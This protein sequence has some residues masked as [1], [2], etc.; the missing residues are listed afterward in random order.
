[1]RLADDGSNGS[2][3]S[4]LVGV[5]LVMSNFV[6][7]EYP[8]RCDLDKISANRP[9]LINSA[10]GH[11]KMVNSKAIER[12][13]IPEGDAAPDGIFFENAFANYCDEMI[14]GIDPNSDKRKE[15]IR[16]GIHGYSAMGL[17]TLHTVS[18]APEEAQTEYVDQYFEL[19]SAGELPVRIVIHPTLAAPWQL[20]PQTGFGTDMVR[21]GGL[22]IF[23]DGALGG[24]S[25]ALL[26]PYSDAP[27]ESGILNFTEDE[28][29]AQMQSGYDAG[30]EV[31]I[32]AI[33]DAAMERIVSAAEAVYP[34][35]ENEDPAE[36]LR[37]A[38]KRRLRIIHAMVVNDDIIRRL[39]RLP[40]ILDVQPGFIDDDVD[41]AEDRLGSERVNYFLPLKS[42]MDNGIMVAGGSDYPFGG[43]P[44]LA[45]IQCAVTRKNL[46]GFPAG[47]LAPSEALSVYRA[48]SMF[49]RNA[50][51][52][53][54]EENQKGTITAGK[55]ADLVILDRD[56]FTTPADKIST[57]KILKTILG[58]AET[59]ACQG[60][61]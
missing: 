9:I 14:D 24:R 8:S 35:S 46:S 18:D 27:S 5:G 36:R 30:L 13:N 3:D 29:R 34:L 1:M 47:G 58:G 50:A 45:A 20:R 55:F 25:A 4:W 39:R 23:L 48:T 15:L 56:I 43:K 51:Y 22:K 6:G 26:R 17:T 54:S 57:I 2:S 33:G 31:S 40:V 12:A 53:S 42:F 28:L 11:I 41:Y 59:W 16:N 19:E 60:D 61:V 37:A 21:I 7:E 44:P 38:G 32:H 52:G 49:T 10:C